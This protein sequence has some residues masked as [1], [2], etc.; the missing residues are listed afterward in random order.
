MRLGQVLPLGTSG[1]PTAGFSN[2]RRHSSG[3]SSSPPITSDEAELFKKSVKRDVANFT[4]FS[5]R[6]LWGAWHLQFKA[7]ARAQ[8]LYDVLDPTFVP[9]PSEVAV[10]KLKNDFMYSVFAAK[11]QTD[12]GRTL[13]RHYEPKPGAPEPISHAQDLYSALLK[14]Y[15]N[16]T[17]AELSANSILTFLTTFK[18]GTDRWK[19]GTVTSFLTYFLEQVRLYDNMMLLFLDFVIQKT[20]KRD[21]TKSLNQYH[22]YVGSYVSSANYRQ[23]RP[24]P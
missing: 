11:L 2:G 5:D 6:R 9:K 23:C 21:K 1:G 8:G 24:P 14:Y 12:E 19:G 16:S 4:V 13:V 7:T 3:A 18:Q 10:F 20:L 22:F 17:H 15:T